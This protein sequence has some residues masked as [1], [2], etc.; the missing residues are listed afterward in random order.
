MAGQAPQ[1]Q[2]QQG[3]LSG[4]LGT[5]VNSLPGRAAMAALD[6]L[7]RPRRAVVSTVQEV[8]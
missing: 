8:A 5:V 2:Q 3:G 6:V 4:F 7:D 1:Q